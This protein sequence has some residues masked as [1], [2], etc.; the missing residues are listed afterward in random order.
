[1]RARIASIANTARR[2]AGNVEFAD[3]STELERPEHSMRCPLGVGVYPSRGSNLLAWVPAFILFALLSTQ[4]SAQSKYGL[5]CDRTSCSA[6][7]QK[8]EERMVNAKTICT[9]GETEITYSRKDV[10]SKSTMQLYWANIHDAETIAQTDFQARGDCSRADL[11]LRINF[12]A[13][14]E[15]VSLSVSDADSGEAVFRENRSVQDSRNDL[16]RAAKHFRSA[17]AAAKVSVEA[18]ETRRNRP[19]VFGAH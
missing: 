13:L 18:R 16:I 6:V 4:A 7:D 3:S 9:S 1:M 17:V 5:N 12:D 15:E 19:T 8:A 2:M 14:A 10:P 11:I